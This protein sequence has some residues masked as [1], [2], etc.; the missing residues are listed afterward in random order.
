MK[1]KLVKYIEDSLKKNWAIDA[2]AD[3]DGKSIKYRET[4]E[5]ILKLHLFFE[6]T[7]IKK[8]DKIALLGNN[9]VNWSVVFLATV[10]YGAVIVPILPDFGADNIHHIVDHSDSVYFFVSDQVWKNIDPDKMPQ[11]KTIFSLEISSIL[12]SRSKKTTEIYNKLGNLFEEKYPL[13]INPEHVS[14]PDIDNNDLALI[15]YTSGTTGFSKGVMLSHNSLTANVRYAQRNMPLKAG[16]SILSLLTLAHSFGMAFDFLFPFSLGCH[17]TFLT[18]IPPL[19][20][21]VKAFAQ[22]KPRLIMLVPL[23]PEKIYKKQLLPAIEKPT[24]K[25]LLSI[26]GL[27]TLVYKKMRDKLMKVFG[28]NFHEVVLGG[29]AFNRDAEIIFRKMKFPFTVGY[30]MTECGPL[31][32]YAPWK[33]SKLGSCGRGVDTLEIKID[34]DDPE[35]IVGEIMVRGEN[36]MDGY[37]KNQEATAQAIDEDGWL[38]TGDLGVIDKDGFIFIR[39][40][41][42]NMILG[43]SGKNIYPE[44]IES[45]INNCMYIQESLVVERDEKLVALVYPDQDKF[46]EFDHNKNKLLTTLNDYLKKLNKKLP[47]HV[48]IARFEIMDEEFEKTPK[49]SLKRYL[50]QEKK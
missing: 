13:G 17:I 49:K 6:K 46:K 26:P 47:S 40:R 45:E 11:L 48:N 7:G 20:V 35:N 38:H 9:S 31:I 25:L 2:L 19:P 12:F 29:A 34:S 30:G 3:Y 27:N 32:S 39:G 42:K 22:V 10:T 4:A 36:V 18:R 15:S 44:E 23:I 41:N 1:E 8:G 33:E 50:Y 43:P 16:D 28:N 5:E 14:F 24:T 21:L 37:Y